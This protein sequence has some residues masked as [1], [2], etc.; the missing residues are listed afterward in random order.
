MNI[1]II[2]VAVAGPADGSADEVVSPHGLPSA[3]SCVAHDVEA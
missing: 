3:R 2:D 1:R